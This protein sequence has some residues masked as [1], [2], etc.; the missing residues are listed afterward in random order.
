M[1]W[2]AFVGIDFFLNYY[3]IIHSISIKKKAKY[4]FLKLAFFVENRKKLQITLQTWK[5]DFMKCSHIM[6]VFNNY[7]AYVTIILVYLIWPVMTRVLLLCCPRIV[8][9]YARNVGPQGI[10]IISVK[11]TVRD[12]DL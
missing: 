5:K 6:C 1:L 9:T 3:G 12:S 11:C 10:R 2:N 4:V 7:I 8:G